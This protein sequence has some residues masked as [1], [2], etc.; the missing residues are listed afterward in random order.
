[1]Y[2][3]SPPSC[4]TTIATI[5]STLAIVEGICRD[6]SFCWVAACV[7]HMIWSTSASM[8]VTIGFIVGFNSMSPI[9]SAGVD[10]VGAT[11][12]GTIGKFEGI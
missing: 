8:G 4:A 11:S 10:V 9:T 3:S 12:G 6:V 5:A 2:Y 7:T 1:M